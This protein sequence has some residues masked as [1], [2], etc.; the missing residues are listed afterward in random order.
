MLMLWTVAALLLR[1]SEDYWTVWNVKIERVYREGNVAADCLAH[2]DSIASYGLCI[3]R[4]V[5]SRL[6]SISSED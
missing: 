4:D 3:L 6:A 1:A 5:P 2:M